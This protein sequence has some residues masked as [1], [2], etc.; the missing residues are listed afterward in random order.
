MIEADDPI[1]IDVIRAAEG[2]RP[3]LAFPRPV[4]PSNALPMLPGARS[5]RWP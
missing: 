4:V 2:D 5:A 1:W 3:A